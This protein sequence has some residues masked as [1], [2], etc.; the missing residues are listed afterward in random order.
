MLSVTFLGTGASI[1]T[2]DRNV[3]ALALMREG[4]TLLFDCGEGTQRQMMRYHISYAVFC[5]KKKNPATHSPQT[6]NDGTSRL[7]RRPHSLC[8][9]A[10]LYWSQVLV[11]SGR[12]AEY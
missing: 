4:E 5:L 7:P 10:T 8:A 1:P 9:A 12:A 2:I 6:H 3:A 11:M